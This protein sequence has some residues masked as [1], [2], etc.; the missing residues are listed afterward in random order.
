MEEFE[1]DDFDVESDMTDSK[2]APEKNVKFMDGTTNPP[3]QFQ[4]ASRVPPME[5]PQVI[6]IIITQSAA[7]EMEFRRFKILPIIFCVVYLLLI[8]MLWWNAA[9]FRTIEG[10]PSP[11]LLTIV[12]LVIFFG[13]IWTWFRCLHHA[14]ASGSVGWI[15]FLFVINLLLLLLVGYAFF[16]MKNI[17]FASF[18]MIFLWISTVILLFV[19][20][21]FWMPGLL[22][23]LIYLLVVTWTWIRF[24]RIAA[25]MVNARTNLNTSLLAS[26][27][28]LPASSGFMNGMQNIFSMKNGFA[29]EPTMAS[30]ENL[31]RDVPVMD[32]TSPKESPK[33]VWQPRDFGVVN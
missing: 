1:D 27:S 25:A 22:W 23:M 33:N 10:R 24:G 13:I 31:N 5:P 2:R 12:W 8:A 9:W 20:T 29:K 18:C 6:P 14:Q 4:Q 7:P 30:S 15:S 19:A 17:A 16:I 28:G 26:L 21:R 11:I 32:E 3:S